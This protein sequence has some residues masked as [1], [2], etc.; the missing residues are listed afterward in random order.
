MGMWV[1]IGDG[2]GMGVMESFALEGED[3]EGVDWLEQ[4]WEEEEKLG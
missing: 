1:G 2:Q 3:E 4:Y